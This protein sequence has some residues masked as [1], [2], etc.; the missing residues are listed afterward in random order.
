M[1]TNKLEHSIN[2]SFDEM[3][4]IIL[5]SKER[6]DYMNR[7][8]AMYGDTTEPN[9]NYDEMIRT[10]LD[11]LQKTCNKI[12]AKYTAIQIEEYKDRII[13][14]FSYL[15]TID[16]PSITTLNIISIQCV[17]FF[18]ELVKIAHPELSTMSNY[19]GGSED[20]Q[21]TYQLLTE[22]K[23]WDKFNFVKEIMLADLLLKVL[24]HREYTEIELNCPN[25]SR[26]RVLALLGNFSVYE[27]I[28]SLSHDVFLIGITTD[29]EMAD[30]HKY[31]PFEFM[32]HDMIHAI[33]R[34]YNGYTIEYSKPFIKHVASI[35]NIDAI[36]AINIILFIIMHESIDE[37][38][39][40]ERVLKLNDFSQIGPNFVS[41]IEH[42]AN[43]DHYGGL[44]PK[45]I[46]ENKSKITPYLHSA[47]NILATE[48]NKYFI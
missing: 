35:D 37:Y 28:S 41:C 10:N 36:T 16:K 9:P 31:T 6:E 25:L 22:S 46:F 13:N 40:S 7:L 39:L 38:L 12:L 14:I 15:D 24:I 42:W 17:I 20:I 18:T 4:D 1:S 26:C 34:G 23:Q 19:A 45:T 47:Y 11:I 33:N 2:T 27:L 8:K 5:N 3:P 21:R 43:I 30:G 48:W 29:L 32:H 44:L